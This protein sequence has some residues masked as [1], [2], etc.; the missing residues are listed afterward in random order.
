MKKNIT[1]NSGFL[2]VGKY[3]FTS[4]FPCALQKTVYMLAFLC[5]EVDMLV[6]YDVGLARILMF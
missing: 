2:Y 6:N 3:N 1:V 5:S 4:R